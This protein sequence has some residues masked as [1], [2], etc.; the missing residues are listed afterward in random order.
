MT[1]EK[2]QQN[3]WFAWAESFLAD[4]KAR[5]CAW[6]ESVTPDAARVLAAAASAAHALGQNYIGAEHLLAGILKFSSGVVAAALKD[7][8]LS[9]AVLKEEIELARGSISRKRVEG[10]LSYTPRYKS[11]VARARDR[12]RDR[13]ERIDVADL[14]LELLAEKEGLPATIISRRGIDV[15]K[16]KSAITRPTDSK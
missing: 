6:A 4:S 15:E 14:L 11:I 1:S 5:D 13:G 12:A 8:G 3:D 7:S 2:T 16:V 9:L 10:T